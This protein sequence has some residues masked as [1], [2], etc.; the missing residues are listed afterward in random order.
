MTD[1]TPAWVDRLDDALRNFNHH[2][3]DWARFYRFIIWQHEQPRSQRPDLVSLR[4]AIAEQHPT[5]LWRRWTE[6]LLTVFD[7]C[8][9][10]LD[11]VT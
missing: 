9:R 6:E 3:L 7:H 1:G 2:P 10:L 4:A 5:D 11:E 8:N